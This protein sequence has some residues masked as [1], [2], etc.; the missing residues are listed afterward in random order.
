MLPGAASGFCHTKIRS[1]DHPQI[2]AK[3]GRASNSGPLEQAPVCSHALQEQHVSLVSARPN[4]RWLE[5][6]S[7]P[8][9][10]RAIRPLV[11]E[12]QP[13]VAPGKPGI[14]VTFDRDKLHAA[15]EALP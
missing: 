7:F 13:A 3:D 8:K 10:R 5:V 15:Q 12:D 14:G 6:H 2:H 1:R 9:H 4:G 11:V